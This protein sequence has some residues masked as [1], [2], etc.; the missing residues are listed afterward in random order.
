MDVLDVSFTLHS[1]F[2]HYHYHY[3]FDQYTFRVYFPLLYPL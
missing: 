2:H 3:H 1:E